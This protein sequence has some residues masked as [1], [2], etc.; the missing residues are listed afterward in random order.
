MADVNALVQRWQAGDERAAEALYVH[1]RERTFHLALGLLGDTADAEE[2]AQ[3][4][5]TYA[6]LNIRRYDPQRASFA[7]WLHTITVS[8]CR[9]RQ[10]RLRFPTL[11]LHTWLRRGSD[12]A[13]PSPGPEYRAMQS[14]ARSQV[15]E[16]V[17]ELSPA[18]REAIVLRYWGGHTF[19]EMADI[20]GCPLRT[21]QSRVRLAFQEL[22]AV[23]T[24]EQLSSLNEEKV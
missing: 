6:L 17:Q 22:R 20:L 23:L 5:L 13:D 1:Y 7:T 8:R 24:Q 21:A 10:R 11:S 19:Q 14:E 3:E 12:P 2:T 16:A 15:W 4:A 9:D 18:L